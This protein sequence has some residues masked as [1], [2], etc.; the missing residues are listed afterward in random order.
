MCLWNAL[1]IEKQLSLCVQTMVYVWIQS[2]YV[3]QSCSAV[4]T[5]NKHNNTLLGRQNM[6]SQHNDHVI[7]DSITK[8]TYHVHHISHTTIQTITQMQSHSVPL[9]THTAPS[10]NIV[11]IIHAVILKCNFDK[12]M[13]VYMNSW[14]QNCCIITQ[15]KFSLNRQFT[16]NLTP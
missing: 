14:V 16:Y 12:T 15:G 8:T 7:V 4:I 13:A 5:I 3:Q 1:N 2:C 11:I 9:S 6:T 10:A